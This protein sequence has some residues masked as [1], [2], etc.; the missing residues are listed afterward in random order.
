MLLNATVDVGDGIV[1]RFNH[2]QPCQRDCEASPPPEQR[3]RGESDHGAGDV[4]EDDFHC[5]AVG[6]RKAVVLR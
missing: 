5:S 1:G 6:N 3:D 2:Q 4:T